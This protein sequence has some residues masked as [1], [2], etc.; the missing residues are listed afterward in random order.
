LSALSDDTRLGGVSLPFPE[1]T[2]PL[3]SRAEVFLD[4]LD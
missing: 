3:A 4:Y 2:D 1:P